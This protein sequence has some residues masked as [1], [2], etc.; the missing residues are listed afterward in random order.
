MSQE[1]WKTFVSKIL[2][3]ISPAKWYTKLKYTAV[4]NNFAFVADFLL[5][6]TKKM[7][8]YQNVLGDSKNW[9]KLNTRILQH[10]HSDIH[11]NNLEEWKTLGVRLELNKTI[12]VVHH[13]NL[14]WIFW[15]QWNLFRDSWA[16]L[17]IW[18]CLTRAFSNNP[19]PYTR[20]HDFIPLP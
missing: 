18:S 19:A 10:K 16:N 4:E 17:T 1:K 5:F 20:K 13:K 3:S 14:T 15:K 2:E 6:M 7:L 12:E 11:L 9:W 8:V